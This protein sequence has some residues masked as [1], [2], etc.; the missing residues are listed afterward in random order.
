M[1][2][3]R[4]SLL[5][6]SLAK[7]TFNGSNVPVQPLLSQRF[8]RKKVMLVDNNG[9]ASQSFTIRTVHGDVMVVSDAM[10]Q[11]WAHFRTIAR[12][13]LAAK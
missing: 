5:C 4:D 3:A 1:L 8:G 7:Q 9:N 10:L 13:K 2:L 12:Q 11:R 6:T